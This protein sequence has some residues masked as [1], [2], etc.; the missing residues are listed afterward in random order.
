MVFLCPNC[1]ERLGNEHHPRRARTIRCQR[2]E[3]GSRPVKVN[4]EE[5]PRLLEL[6]QLGAA[7]PPP[8]PSR[9]FFS[10]AHGHHC[11]AMPITW[12]GVSGESWGVNPLSTA[13]RCAKP[14]GHQLRNAQPR[15]LCRERVPACVSSGDVTRPSFPAHQSAAVNDRYV[16][17]PE[18]PSST[19]VAS[20]CGWPGRAPLKRLEEAL[21]PARKLVE[22]SVD[23]A[24]E[25]WVP[26]GK[27]WVVLIWLKKAGAG[28]VGMQ[29]H[30]GWIQVVRFHG[31]GN[32]NHSSILAWRIPWTEEPGGVRSM[33]SQRVGHDW[34]TNTFT[35]SIS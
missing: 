9:D 18:C 30:L 28:V 31:E 14:R 33:E 8:N 22:L 16:T 11:E 10:D 4:A 15:L 25:S 2:K 12:R 19:R 21:P 6:D 35:F 29:V 32:G 20:R 13:Q 17:P 24:G 27:G 34:A 3:R 23:L 7:S 26:I 1:N 5:L